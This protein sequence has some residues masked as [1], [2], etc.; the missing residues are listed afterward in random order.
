MDRQTVGVQR[1][2]TLVHF[3][4]IIIYSLRHTH[5]TLHTTIL[6]GEL[7]YTSGRISLSHLQYNTVKLAIAYS[8]H[9]IIHTHL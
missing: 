3:R 7:T 8:V 5:N 4:I 1:N 2:T 6:S 9:G